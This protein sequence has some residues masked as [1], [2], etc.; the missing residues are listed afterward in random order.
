VAKYREELRIPASSIR[1][2]GAPEPAT[3]ASPAEPEQVGGPH[4][5]DADPEEEP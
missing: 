5:A 2:V 4:P 1:R 3:E